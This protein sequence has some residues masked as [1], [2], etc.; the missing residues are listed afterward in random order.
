MYS[1]ILFWLTPEDFTRQGGTSLEKASILF[2]LSLGGD[3]E[4]SA[5]VMNERH[6]IDS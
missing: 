6:F 4:S 5:F 2:Q 3:N 1:T